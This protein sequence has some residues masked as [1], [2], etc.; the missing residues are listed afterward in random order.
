MIKNFDADISL[1]YLLSLDVHEFFKRNN[2]NLKK[3]KNKLIFIIGSPRSGTTV[4]GSCIGNHSEIASGDESLFLIDMWRI[5]SD[6]YQGRNHQDWAPLKK[7]I[8]ED[9]ILKTIKSF[10]D[11][12][13]YS[14]M[15][16]NK[17]SMY[18]DHTPWYILLIPFI[19]IIY[20]NSVF[21]H[22]I[23]DGRSVVKSLARSYELGFKWAGETLEERTRLWSKLVEFGRTSGPVYAKDSYIEIGYENFCCNPES[24]LI[25]ICSFIGLDFEKNTLTP[26]TFP[27]AGPSRKEAVI[28]EL[29]TGDRVQIKKFSYEKWQGEWTSIEKETFLHFGAETLVKFGYEL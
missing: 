18:V 14:F 17:K 29:L 25:T 7:Y 8:A 6:L 24:T 26:L 5:F 22:I 11:S 1:E 27:H 9:K 2:I 21:I 3:E 4:L 20:P 16:R 13:F 23:R 12:I 28:G 15:D 10:G 19:K